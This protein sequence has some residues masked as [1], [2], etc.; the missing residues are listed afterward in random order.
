MVVVLLWFQIRAYALI[1]LGLCILALP[2][3][4]FIGTK[5]G[6]YYNK[7]QEQTDIRIKLV[8]ELISAIRVVKVIRLY[9]ALHGSLPYE[10]A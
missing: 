8:S 5:M 10:T 7:R 6:V 3:G 4:G 1:S 9:S 2:L